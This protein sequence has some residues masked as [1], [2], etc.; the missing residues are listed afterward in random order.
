MHE[1]ISSQPNWRSDLAPRIILG[2]WETRFLEPAARL[3]PYC[4]R[5]HLGDDPHIAR[6]QFWKECNS[7]SMD[8]NM[9]ATVEGEMYLYPSSPLHGLLKNVT[10]SEE[11]V[12]PP[13]RK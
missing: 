10:G 3:M 13:A 8:Y 2:L 9:L 1:I 12:S 4:A 6:T 7:F 5:C 11:I